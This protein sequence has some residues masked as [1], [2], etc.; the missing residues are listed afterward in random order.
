MYRSRA[1]AVLQDNVSL[2]LAQSSLDDNLEL[3]LINCG[4]NVYK[5]YKHNISA[6]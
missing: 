1:A 4:A 2:K 5:Y 3:L 6:R